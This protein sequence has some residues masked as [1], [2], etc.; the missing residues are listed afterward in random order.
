MICP[1]CKEEMEFEDGIHGWNER[2]WYCSECE[3]EVVEDIT[4]DMI[5][6]A[7]AQKEL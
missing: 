4:G 6:Y 7:M 1:K 2:T 3:Y 5:D